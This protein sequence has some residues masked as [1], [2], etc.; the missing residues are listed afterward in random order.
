MSPEKLPSRSSSDD[1]AHSPHPGARGSSDLNGTNRDGRD[2]L[3][4]FYTEINDIEQDD[5][6]GND[7]HGSDDDQLKPLDE[8]EQEVVWLHEAGYGHLASKFA[9]DEELIKDDTSSLTRAQAAAVRKRVDTLNATVRKKHKQQLK[10]DVRDVFTG[11]SSEVR[12]AQPLCTHIPHPTPPTHFLILPRHQESICISFHLLISEPHPPPL[13]SLSLSLSPAE[14]SKSK[15]GSNRTASSTDDDLSGITNFVLVKDTLGVT[16]VSDLGK[17]DVVKLHSLAL[18]ELTALF[19]IHNLSYN[20]RKPKRRMKEHGVFGVPLQSLFDHDVKR[21][22]NIKVPLLLSKLVSFLIKT[23]VPEEGILRVP[24]AVARIKSLRQEIEERFNSGRFSWEDVR[25]HDAAGLLKQ[26][27][28]DL[29]VPLLTF[30]YIEAFIAVQKIPDSRQQLQALNLLVLLLPDVHRNTLQLL[31]QFLKRICD[32]KENKMTL[33]NVAMIMAPNLFLVQSRKSQPLKRDLEIS[34][35]A[36]TSNVIKMLIKFQDILWSVPSFMISQ[37]RHQYEADQMRSSGN[38]SQIMK[39]LGRKDKS[40]TP[41]KPQ[42]QHEGD[43]QAGVIRVQ[44]PHMNMCATAVQLDGT[45]TASDIVARFCRSS[46]VQLA[47]TGNRESGYDDDVV[48][49]GNPCLFEQG[50][51][52]GERR[53]E[54]DTKILALYRVNPNAE[55]VIRTKPD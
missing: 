9:V 46:A 31:L 22:P 17:A 50:G 27:L 32:C 6:E 45:T 18:I 26:F 55:W 19:D 51:N 15:G 53:L 40:D 33:N 10:T 54:S 49:P 2:S 34:T 25:P 36:G 20:R 47:N 42:V 24:G 7:G 14:G 44:A 4:D 30:Q 29:P 48:S 5:D 41:K 13:S 43:F 39:F 38:K 1:T 37:I 21:V 12:S 11:A 3:E 28:R 16:R 8:G 23:G 52:I 35:A